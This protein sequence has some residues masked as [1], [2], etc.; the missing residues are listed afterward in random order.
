[1]AEA[2]FSAYFP[3]STVPTLIND[4]CNKTIANVFCFGTFADRH[5]GV[6]Y[7]LGNFPF[8]WFDG[9]LCFLIMYHH[10]ANGIMAT[11]IA[12]LDDMCNFNTYKLKSDNLTRKG[13]KPMLNIIDNQ[14]RKYINYFLPRGMQIT[15]GQTA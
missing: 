4:N 2:Q 13:Y 1:M 5:S 10:K 12:G 15:V 3:Q 6:V 7:N 8:M 14:A 9:S 11:L